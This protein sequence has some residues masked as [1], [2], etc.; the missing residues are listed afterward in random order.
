[1][2]PLAEY[3]QPVGAYAFHTTQKENVE[4]IRAQGI[5]HTADTEGTTSS[6]AAV[7]ND[8]GY[9]SPFPF[10]RSAVVYCGVDADFSAEMLPSQ[11]EHG[12]TDGLVTVVVAV[13][14]ITAPMYVADMSLA[15]DLL[16]YR[17]GGA[18]IMLHADTPDKAVEAYRDSI[19]AVE[20]PAEIATQAETVHHP[21]LVIKGDVHTD[22]IADVVR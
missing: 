2:N 12:L 1:M 14:A 20:T 22:A 9:D 4:S 16:D 6:V 7:L 13:D 8:L 5:S 15:G 21:E 17:Y 10:D 18:D 19:E 3:A 11:S